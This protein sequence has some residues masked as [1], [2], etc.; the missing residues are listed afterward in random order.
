MS[1]GKKAHPQLSKYHIWIIWV[2]EI[3][4]FQPKETP[5]EKHTLSQS[6]YILCSLYIVWDKLCVSSLA[7][8]GE[9]NGDVSCLFKIFIC[10]IACSR[11]SL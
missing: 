6:G 10:F 7:S 5:S 8:V 11:M 3:P 9:L 1:L 4:D 2:Y